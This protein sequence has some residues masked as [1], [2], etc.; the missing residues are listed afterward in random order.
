MEE[1]GRQDARR[2]A[3]SAESLTAAAGQRMVQ[4]LPAQTV[5]DRD[6]RGL[7]RLT[8]TPISGGVHGNSQR[9]LCNVTEDKQF[10]L[11][12]RLPWTALIRHA[13]LLIWIEYVIG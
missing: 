3:P 11:L 1:V 8:R 4:G 7:I 6:L 5:A 13:R 10:G 12:V 2:L 9:K